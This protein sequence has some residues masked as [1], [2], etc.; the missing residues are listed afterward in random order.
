MVVIEKKSN[1][2]RREFGNAGFTSFAG[3]SINGN[4][5]LGT[6]GKLLEY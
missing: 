3:E 5:T 4:R 1:K 2:G 6:V